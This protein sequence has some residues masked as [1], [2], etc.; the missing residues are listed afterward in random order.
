MRYIAIRLVITAALVTCAT[1]AQTPDDSVKVGLLRGSLVAAGGGAPEDVIARFIALAG[2]PDAPIVSIPPS[3]AC[4]LPGGGQ[5]VGD[6]CSA[7]GLGAR[8]PCA[9]PPVA[10]TLAEGTASQFRAAGARNVTVIETYDRA[11]ADSESF[12]AKIARASG[13][14][15]PGGVPQKLMEVYGGTRTER[16]LRNLLARGG[17]V[18]GTSA[19]AVILGSHFGFPAAVDDESR[20]TPGFGFLRNVRFLPHATSQGALPMLAILAA[21][22]PD[23]VLLAMD[24]RAAWEIHGDTAEVIGTGSAFV[25]GE[26]PASPDRR[27]LTLRAGDRYNMATRVVTRA[28]R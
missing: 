6:G 2:G 10:Q 16:E 12:V 4:V 26:G 9:P 21:R 23:R 7:G 3:P 13:F 24:E 19:G 5:A 14:W 27:Y 20:L 8:R 18:G 17:V 11:V 22:H 28:T 15:A 25:P 1:S